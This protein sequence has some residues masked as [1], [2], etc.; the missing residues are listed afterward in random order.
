M[1]SIQN[2][3]NEELERSK[4]LREYAF[5]ASF[6][7]GQKIRKEQ[8]VAFKKFNFYKNLSKAIDKENRG[9]KKWN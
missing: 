5:D 3:I 4:K 6:E 1:K 9:D 2:K 8:D 7:N